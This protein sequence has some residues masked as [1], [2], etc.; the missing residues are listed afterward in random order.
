MSSFTEKSNERFYNSMKVKYG[1]QQR[2]EIGQ[3]V[4]TNFGQGK[5]LAFDKVTGMYK[6]GVENIGLYSY[7]EFWFEYENLVLCE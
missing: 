2:F 5:V 4:H 3:R 1:I 6:V 7:R